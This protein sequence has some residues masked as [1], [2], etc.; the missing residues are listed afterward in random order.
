MALADTSKVLILGSTFSSLPKETTFYTVSIQEN[1]CTLRVYSQKS[2]NQIVKLTTKRV[3]LA[4]NVVWG[5][6]LGKSC[7]MV[8]FDS[9]EIGLLYLDKVFL[10]NEDLGFVECPIFGKAFLLGKNIDSF[11]DDEDNQN[12]RKMS[13]KSKIKLTFQLHFYDK[14]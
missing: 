4:Q 9:Y 7:A 2:E 8:I 5:S 1:E 14:Y 11:S 10:G 3:C 6:L 13:E 12:Y